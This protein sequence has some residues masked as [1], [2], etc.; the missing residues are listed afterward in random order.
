MKLARRRFLSLVGL[1]AALPA[2]AWAQSYPARPVRIVV[3]FPPGGGVDITARLLGQWLS[4]RFGKTFFVENR[5]GAGSNL[6]TETVVRAPP[7]GHTLLL[8]D[9][10]PATNA[11]SLYDKL[12]FN[13]MRDIA[14]ASGLR[15]K[16]ARAWCALDPTTR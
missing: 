7:D 11:S 3:G 6:A 14:P 12:D 4:E 1:A 15:S 8:F 2:A 16:A 9:A 5:P 10:P 13:F